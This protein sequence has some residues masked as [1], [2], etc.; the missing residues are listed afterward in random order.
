MTRPIAWSSDATSLD[1]VEDVAVRVFEDPADA[2]ADAAAAA[3][4]AKK[5]EDE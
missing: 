2:D 4:K 1:S 5:D 3:A